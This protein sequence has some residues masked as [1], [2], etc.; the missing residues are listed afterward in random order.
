M[1]TKALILIPARYASTRFPGKPIA[2]I[3]GKPMIIRVYEGCEEVANNFP[4]SKVVIVTD[5]DRIENEVKKWNKEVVRV[6]DD[7]P[8]GSERIY[9]AYER[10]FASE[11]EYDLV[12]NVQ[13]DEP[14]IKSSLL[15]E[16]ISFHANSEFDVATVVKKQSIKHVSY[17]DPNKV[18]AIYQPSSGKCHF[19][20]RASAPHYRDRSEGDW[21]LHVGVYSFRP[22]VLKE[23]C[24]NGKSFYEDIECLEQLRLIE[25]GFS[26]GALMS[27]VNL[28]GVD[29][30]ED[31]K[32]VEE[33]FN[34]K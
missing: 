15:T 20:T 7:V 5:D 14:L 4:G 18:K 30:P 9:L 17:L 27:D 11:G 2:K 29:T 1:D 22:H 31:L 6:D 13:G 25:N 3:Q 10:Y 32:A 28:L 21:Y 19:F 12:I 24:S 8:S 33:V 26:I 23:F 16:I 34:G